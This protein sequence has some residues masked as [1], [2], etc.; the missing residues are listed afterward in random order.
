MGVISKKT[1]N[2]SGSPLT[3]PFFLLQLCSLQTLQILYLCILHPPFTFGL[4][5]SILLTW[6]TLPAVNLF[7]SSSRSQI[8][9]SKVLFWLCHSLD[10]NHPRFPTAHGIMLTSYLPLQAQIKCQFPNHLIQKLFQCLLV[11][12]FSVHFLILL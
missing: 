2:I 8:N 7:L 5:S 10:Q 1:T 3:S 12:W 11:L 6:T 4:R 9:L